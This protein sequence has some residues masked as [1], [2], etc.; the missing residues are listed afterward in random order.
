MFCCQRPLSRKDV[1]GRKQ[2]SLKISFNTNV[3]ITENITE[4]LK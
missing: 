4:N 1:F 3:Y 2:L